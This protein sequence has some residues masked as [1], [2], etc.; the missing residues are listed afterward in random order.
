[1]NL[2]FLGGGNMASAIIAGLYQNKEFNIFV[3][4]KHKEKLNLLQKKYLVNVMLSLPSI[5]S[6]DILLLAVKPQNLKDTCNNVNANNNPLIISIAAGISISS[7]SKWTNSNRIIRAMPNLPAQVLKGMTGLYT[8]IDFKEDIN[9]ASMIFNSIGKIFWASDE[10]HL[11]CLTSISG[12]WPGCIFYLMDIVYKEACNLGFSK[13]VAKLLVLE[14][15]EGSVKLAQD[16]G[17]DFRQ[18]QDKVASKGGVT[19]SALDVFDKLSI[20]G[21]IHESIKVSLDKSKDISKSLG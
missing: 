5:N 3:I 21:I 8:N 13:E 18:L 16:S 12:I 17:L 4:D 7:I 20:K 11:D 14:T 9:I 10:E 1:M 15:F 19:Q 2:Y 6:N